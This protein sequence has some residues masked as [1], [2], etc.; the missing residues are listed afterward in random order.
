VTINNFSPTLHR[1]GDTA[2]Q[3][4]KTATFLH[5]SSNFYMNF[6]CEEL[7]LK[8]ISISEDFVSWS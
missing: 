6:I 8:R 4:T 1:F 7:K 3:W 5:H 2:T